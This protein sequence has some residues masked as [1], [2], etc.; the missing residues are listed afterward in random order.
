M[1]ENEATSKLTAITDYFILAHYSYSYFAKLFVI[2][3]DYKRNNFTNFVNIY[4]R[5]LNDR[6]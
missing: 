2:V 1:H 3:K 4:E 6:D 5:I